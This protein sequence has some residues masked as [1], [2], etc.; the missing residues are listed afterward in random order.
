MPLSTKWKECKGNFL[1]PFGK[2]RIKLNIE[3][4]DGKSYTYPIEL[5]NALVT[6]K[7]GEASTVL[8]DRIIL[9]RADSS[10]TNS[11]FTVEFDVDFLILKTM[12]TH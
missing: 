12:I 1:I 11:A 3:I 8:Y 7:N 9:K 10:F 5:C 6:L 2:H 4:D